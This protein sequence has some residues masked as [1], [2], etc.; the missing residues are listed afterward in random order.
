MRISPRPRVSK[1][2]KFLMAK[3]QPAAWA[4]ASVTVPRRAASAA[5][6][7]A[8]SLAITWPRKAA[9]RVSGAVG[10]L[11]AE[12]GSQ[13]ADVKALQDRIASLEQAMADQAAQLAAAKAQSSA[14]LPSGTPSAPSTE[15][16]AVAPSEG[17]TPA[18]LVADG[19]TKD[20]IP[21]N[22]RFMATSGDSFP[23]CKTKVV[24]K[25]ASVSDGFATI[26]GPGDIAA[27]ASGSLAK[28]CT[29]MVFSADTTGYAEMRVT[30]Q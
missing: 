1:A 17:A 14:P 5:W 28:G 12:G 13:V 23:I 11:L 20:C 15:V 26:T 30:C 27:G 25:V 3:P 6:N 21:I 29:V 16:A 9:P 4:C 22:T 19:P 24:V 7:R 8:S 10:R 18:A 2:A